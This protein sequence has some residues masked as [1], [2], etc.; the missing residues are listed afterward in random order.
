LNHLWK[1][2][3]IDVASREIGLE[4]AF[5]VLVLIVVRETCLFLDLVVFVVANPNDDGW[6]VTQPTHVVD[7][8]FSDGLEQVGPGRVVSAAKHKV[9]PNHHAEFVA[10][11]VEAVVL[12]IAATPYSATVRYAFMNM[13][14]AK[15]WLT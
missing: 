9:L 8:F 12:I 11:V 10:R 14:R 7:S 5:G 3:L 2:F 6:V 13:T 15:S 1:E 4:P